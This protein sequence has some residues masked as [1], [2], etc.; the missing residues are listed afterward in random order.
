MLQFQSFE[1]LKAEMTLEFP[2]PPKS[3]SH[4]IQTNLKGAPLLER[5]P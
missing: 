2:A 5:C 3:F 1:E 4:I